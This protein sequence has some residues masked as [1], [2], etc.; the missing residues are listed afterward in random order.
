M[1]KAI[2]VPTLEEMREYL[3]SFNADPIHNRINDTEHAPM[4]REMTLRIFSVD[5]PDDVK[6]TAWKF[7]KELTKYA[8]APVSPAEYKRMEKWL[9]ETVLIDVLLKA[10]EDYYP[11]PAFKYNFDTIGFSYSIALISQSQ[12]RRA[13]CL[14]LLDK[15]TQYYVNTKDDWYTVLL[16]NMTKFCKQFPDLTGFKTAL[17][18]I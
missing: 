13:D 15:I 5:M 9:P 7:C 18:S 3:K 10:C 17:E 6:I 14:A 12:Y 2:K 16:R 8:H 4:H 11:N 1:A